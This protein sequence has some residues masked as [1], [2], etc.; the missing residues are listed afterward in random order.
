MKTRQEMMKTRKSI[1]DLFKIT[2]LRK[3]LTNRYLRN[4]PT[5]S[6]ITNCVT[7]SMKSFITTVYPEHF[8]ILLESLTSKT[9]SFHIIL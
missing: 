2:I 1:P 4:T 6:T 5:P 7:I 9:R 8:L 3:F